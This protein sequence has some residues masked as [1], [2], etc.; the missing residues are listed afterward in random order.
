M[1]VNS[2]PKT[3]RRLSD[4]ARRIIADVYLVG[5]VDAEAQNILKDVSRSVSIVGRLLNGLAGEYAAAN[6][7]LAHMLTVAGSVLWGIVEISVPESAL[8]YLARNWFKLAAALGALIVVLGVAMNIAGMPSVGI[9]FLV[10]RLYRLHALRL[11]PSLHELRL[12][13]HEGVEKNPFSD[14]RA[15]GPAGRSLP[16]HRSRAGYC[17]HPAAHGRL[18]YARGQVLSLALLIDPRLPALLPRPRSCFCGFGASNNSSSP[19]GYK[20]RRTTSHLDC[21]RSKPSITQVR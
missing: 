13:A 20:G 14:P 3:P 1:N 10:R 7:G 5:S 11:L 8:F 16:A 21:N 9:D 15:A 12:G 19:T 6:K 18:L 17:R 4:P 2:I